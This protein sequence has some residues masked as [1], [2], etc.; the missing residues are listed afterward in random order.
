MPVSLPSTTL[1][2]SQFTFRRRLFVLP[3]LARSVVRIVSGVFLIIWCGAVVAFLF[4]DIVRVQWLGILLAL[5]LID[6][7]I[8]SPRAHYTLRELYQG[9]VP[10]HN[11]ALCANRRALHTTL[12]ALERAETRG[13]D[14]WLW[15][16]HRL[17]SDDRVIRNALERLDVSPHE[18]EQALEQEYE[19]SLQSEKEQDYS[20]ASVSDTYREQLLSGISALFI[21]AAQVAYAH[22]LSY[23]D[24]SVLCVALLQTP[25][26]RMVKVLDLFSI[27][28]SDVDG[29]FAFGL[30]ASRARWIPSVV[31]GFARTHRATIAKHRVNRTLT[32][33]PTPTLDAFAYDVTELARAGV[34]GFLIGHKDEYTRMVDVL[35]GS[36]NRNVLLVGEEG[37]GKE[38]I[39]QH[40][41]FQI[42][43]DAVPAP[44]FDRRVVAL[45]ISQLVAG[46]SGSDGAAR[47]EK[48]ADEIIRA[49]NIVLYIPDVHL[50]A[51]PVE[52]GGMLLTE[53][54]MPILRASAFPI[55]G[56]T[57]PREYNTYI[58]P[59]SAFSG[60]FQMMRVDELSVEDTAR[61]LS[62]EALILEK[63]H[64]VT[65]YFSAIRQAAILAAKYLHQKPLPSAAQELLA[66]VVSNILQKGERF[67]KGS[68]V[69]ET[70]ERR[71]QVPIHRASKDEA[72]HLLKLE[73][74]IHQNFIDQEE[75]VNAVANAL[76]AYR[77]GL[78]RR[79]GPIASFLFVGPTGVGKTE[80]S[81]LLAKINFGS[82]SF[83]L[84]FDMSEYQQ[85][86]A[87]ARFIGSPDGVISGALTE[88]VLAHPY[89][90]VLLDEIEKAH[91]DILNLFLQVLD[92]GH[93]T[94]ALGRKVDFTNTIII[95][96]SNAHSVF[97]QERVRAG[98]DVSRLSDELKRKL[99]DVFRPEFLNRFSDI[100]MFRPLEP[101][102][103]EQIARLQIASLVRLVQETNAITLTVSDA[104]V[105]Y[106]AQLG[107]DPAFGARPLRKAIDT[108]LKA[109]LSQKILSGALYRGM[110]VEVDVNEKGEIIFSA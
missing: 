80:L 60:L 50:L 101:E 97:I 4:S 81:K 43:S 102:H 72:R 71:V 67:V 51:H 65:I 57:Y 86:D 15:L 52:G 39:V 74:I 94:D 107:Y 100:V 76:R 66:E 88:A 11:V 36:E 34:G 14:M 25:H 95:A 28:G 64:R 23:I 105:K 44:L 108:S 79:G 3:P 53:S 42:I 22:G 96:T 91:P 2:S 70:V 1:I 106:I 27:S 18:F 93:L 77:S 46:V 6:F 37:T 69:I 109:A 83:M 63:K 32:S 20:Y 40:L 103:I 99:S 92:D 47:L 29:A 7:I 19:K 33:R 56:S 48:I 61:L 35:C 10:N 21:R 104:V 55:I 75:A 62:Y 73:E 98:E 30:F 49:G 9:R 5:M 87:I 90:L 82:D 78:S 24:L 84:R 12:M 31:G 38:T 58:Q 17:V 45:S 16:A 8:H 89:S 13:G 54:L 110:S 41:A 26:P 68:D 59:N 85:K